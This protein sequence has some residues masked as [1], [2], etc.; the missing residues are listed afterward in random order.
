[1]KN[2]GIDRV[3]IFNWVYTLL[4]LLFCA[5]VIITARI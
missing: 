4:L 1:M 2:T 3:K 5:G